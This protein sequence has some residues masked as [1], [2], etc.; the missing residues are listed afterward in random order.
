MNETNNLRA[1]LEDVRGSYPEFV[2]SITTGARK[3]GIEDLILRYLVD[4]PRASVSD[5]SLFE[6]YLR[7][8]AKYE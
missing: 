3:N 7:G 6:L 2:E 8:V 4:N 5:V 1:A